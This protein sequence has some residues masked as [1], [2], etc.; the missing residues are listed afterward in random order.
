MIERLQFLSAN[1]VFFKRWAKSYVESHLGVGAA[2]AAAV[3]AWQDA[4]AA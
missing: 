1:L 4:K 3:A 2:H